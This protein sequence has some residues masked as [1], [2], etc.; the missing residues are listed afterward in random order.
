MVILYNGEICVLLL[1]CGVR[2]QVLEG[3]VVGVSFFF[4]TAR[5]VGWC[6]GGF[7]LS[8]W[9][10]Q[11]VWR[12]RKVPVGMASRR[13]GS[14]FHLLQMMDYKWIKRNY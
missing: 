2:T 14:A 11:S 6:L 8:P 7:F 1:E 10:Y 12:G 3:D 13:S 4:V 9:L 5:F